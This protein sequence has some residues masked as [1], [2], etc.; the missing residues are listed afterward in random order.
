MGGERGKGKRVKMWNEMRA[1]REKNWEFKATG[2][3]GK[4]KNV[5]G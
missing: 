1:E 5:I 3:R 4:R 2:V